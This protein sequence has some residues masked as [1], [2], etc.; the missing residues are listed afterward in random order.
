MKLL[1]TT[2]L[3]LT[4]T[5]ATKIS[6]SLSGDFLQAPYDAREM[7]MKEEVLQ[8]PF[9]A[10]HIE[11]GEQTETETA[12]TESI[13]EALMDTPV[14][15]KAKKSLQEGEDAIDKMCSQTE[16]LKKDLESK[17]QE[18]KATMKELLKANDKVDKTAETLENAR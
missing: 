18:A 12:Q 16:K 10:G 7:E 5:E 15:K 1:S 14:C 8:E 6:Q 2:T 9:D 4:Y 13:E 3:L 17:D 11:M